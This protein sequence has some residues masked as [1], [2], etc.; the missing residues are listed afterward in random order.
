MPVSHA[1]DGCG[2][3]TGKVIGRDNVPIANAIVEIQNNLSEVFSSTVS[4]A[5]GSFTIDKIPIYG[6]DGRNNF[7]LVATYNSSG[8]SY[9]DK[10]EFFWIYKNQ[11]ITHDV[12][13]YYYPPSNYGWLTG[14]VVNVNDYK[15]YVSSTVYLSNGMY[16]FVSSEPGDNWQFYLPAGDYQ[17][18]AEHNENGRTYSTGKT[19]VH[20]RSDDTFTAV[21]SI[22][23]AG[24]GSTYHAAPAEGVNI[25]HGY[26]KQKN[27]VPLY[28]AVVELC[29]VDGIAFCP[30]MSTTT[31][32]EGNY[33]FKRVTISSPMENF[34]VRVTYN[35]MGND[36]TTVSN[37]FSVYYHNMMNVS[38]DYSVPVTVDFIDSGS[39]EVISDPAGANIWLDG[40]YTGRTT[41]FNITGVRAGEHSCSLQMD[42]YL[43]ENVTVTVHSDGTSRITKILKPSTGDVYFKVNPSDA[44]IYLNGELVGTGST[45]LTRIQYGVYSYT[46]SRDGYR[47]VTASIEVIPGGHLEVPV[48]LVAIP[49]LSL[50]YIGYLINSMLTYIA[51][52]FG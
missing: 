19:S 23:L 33:E 21:L 46:V 18:W 40:A 49:G 36:T 6:F 1:D 10:T 16:D 5:D 17:V 24:N 32:A 42:G 50:T 2:V 48:E 22:S 4:A 52:I 43:P 12:Q 9:K 27:G 51:N 14:K 8:K 38:H 30:V 20:V 11:I 29:R 28:G 45:N 47:N 15:E 34:A 41:P 25:V 13:I 31:N 39:I 26:V 37:A 7:R 3:V 44:S 35:F